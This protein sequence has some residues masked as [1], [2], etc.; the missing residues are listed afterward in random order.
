MPPTLHTRAIHA[1]TLEL[2]M[3]L[4]NV[5]ELRAFALVGGTAL[6]LYKGH[7][8]SLDVDLF[9]QAPFDAELLFAEIR[10]LLAPQRNVQRISI[11][12]NT[13]NL[14]LD[15]IKTD[16]LRFDYPLLEPIDTID[17][18]RLFSLPD[19]AAMKLSAIAGRGAKK[20]FY[21]LDCLLREYTLRDLFAWFEAKFGGDMFHLRKSIVYFD[22]ADT[23]PEPVSLHN[24]SWNEVKSRIR[25]AAAKM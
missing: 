17:G 4:M 1:P 21:D 19:I 24:V 12:R 25:A 3:E 8:I 10:S 22:D 7:R 18:I 13:L 23:E 16:L 6:A 9:T 20:D 5:P 11:A 14:S 15:G 2:L